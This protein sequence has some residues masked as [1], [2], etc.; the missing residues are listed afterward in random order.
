[1]DPVVLTSIIAFREPKTTSKICQMPFSGNAP[2]TLTEQPASYSMIT[3]ANTPDSHS[4][5]P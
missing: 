2:T 1:M 3:T 5:F 4:R